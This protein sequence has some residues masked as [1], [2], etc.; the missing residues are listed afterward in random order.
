MC[1]G[2]V[3]K[4]KTKTENLS[5]L[6]EVLEKLVVKRGSEV[7]TRKELKRLIIWT[8]DLR[9][10]HT[11]NSWLDFL[12]AK[13]LVSF[14]NESDKE[15]KPSN[16]TLYLININPIVRSVSDFLSEELPNESKVS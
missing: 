1:V 3:E 16:N 11:I 10:I 9:D 6:R 5:L 15:K 2:D 12:W 4:M 14:K 8:L 13:G 7:L